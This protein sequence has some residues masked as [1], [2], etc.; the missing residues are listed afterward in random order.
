MVVKGQPLI[1]PGRQASVS[2]QTPEQVTLVA[3]GSVV[4]GIL[5]VESLTP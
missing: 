5:A 4:T 2:V 1:E 3:L